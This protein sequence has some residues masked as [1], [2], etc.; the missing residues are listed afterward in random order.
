MVNMSQR[1][2]NGLNRRYL[3]VGS[4]LFGLWLTLGTAHASERDR[5]F[6]AQAGALIFEIKAAP[7]TS[8]DKTTTHDAYQD[9]RDSIGKF[10]TLGK[11]IESRGTAV[12]F[13][14]A[15]NE[16]KNVA[17][18]TKAE[19]ARLLSEADKLVAAEPLDRLH[20][21]VR[22]LEKD[23]SSRTILI[24]YR[25]EIFTRAHDA[26]SRAATQADLCFALTGA[27]LSTNQSRSPD[28]FKRAFSNCEQALK[29]NE[30]YK[31]TN[32][33]TLTRLSTSLTELLKSTRQPIS[34]SPNARLIQA[35]QD[36]VAIEAEF[37]QTIMQL[38]G[39]DTIRS[40][41]ERYRIDGADTPK[42]TPQE[43]ELINKSLGYAT[44]L[45]NERAMGDAF[46]ALGAW[47][48]RDRK[49][50][51]ARSNY[52]KA[53]DNYTQSGYLAIAPE[54][55]DMLTRNLE[56]DAA[57]GPLGEALR[58]RD[59]AL[60][61]QNY[62]AVAEAE[63]NLSLIYLRQKR[64]HEATQSLLRFLSAAIKTDDEMKVAHAHLRRAR[65][66]VFEQR[67]DEA[68][69]F[70]LT[71]AVALFKKTN[72][73]EQELEAT[74]LLW[75]ARINDPALAAQVLSLAKSSK[76]PRLIAASHRTATGK[77]AL[78]GIPALGQEHAA[79]CSKIYDNL[80]AQEEVAFCESSLARFE[81]ESGE[82]SKACE[83][84]KLAGEKF[85]AVGRPILAKKQNTWMEKAKCKTH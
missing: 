8:S 66:Q 19:A 51:E 42:D 5:W 37:N 27:A 1:M 52:M 48:E 77:Y 74:Q 17:N 34:T 47:Y 14:Y 53:K 39:Y 49:F 69:E 43:L 83:H 38:Q 55:S 35:H 40:R 4:F 60:A 15:L 11:F 61:K 54:T 12:I 63:E 36:P 41:Q 57:D 23:K 79:A 72:A 3:V 84:Y 75:Q 59:G 22:E 70:S 2:P 65:R 30:A 33:T 29:T 25:Y 67:F 18:A 76:S 50:Q 64:P 44:R 80:G 68:M 78:E 82:K 24:S 62:S 26:K 13:T 81:Q 31:K 16:K 46:L 7:T 21:A 20:E 73:T 45:G 28:L 56:F 85:L 71:E 10:R 6:D 9:F 58:R 32:A